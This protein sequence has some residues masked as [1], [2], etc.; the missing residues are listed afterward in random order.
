MK[1]ISPTLFLEI[2][3]TYFN[4]FVCMYDD[5][6]NLSIIHNSEV[7]IIG[8]ED[9]RISDYEKILSVIKENIYLIENKLNYTFKNIV[10]ILENFNLSFINLSGY[11]KLNGSQILRENIT[12]ILNTLRS[13]VDKIESQKTA[14]HIFNSKFCLDN[15]KVE[16][17]P[18]GLFGDFY[19]FTNYHYH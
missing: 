13:Y 15:K 10:L 3:N 7:P 16:N 2:N 11:K 4:F 8:I 17:L 18:I 6:D 1:D 19:S 5:Q 14:I 9:N 12:Y